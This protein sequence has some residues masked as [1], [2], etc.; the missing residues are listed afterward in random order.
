MEE[1]Y[2]LA[3]I[4]VCCVSTALNLN[5][6]RTCNIF[7]LCTLFS[8]SI[9]Y[10][11]KQFLWLLFFRIDL[12]TNKS[13][14]VSFLLMK[15]YLPLTLNHFTFPKKLCC[16]EDLILAGACHWCEAYQLAT[17]HPAACG[18]WLGGR[19]C[20]GD[21]GGSRVA[22]GPHQSWLRQWWLGQ[23]TRAGALPVEWW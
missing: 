22:A 12:W 16:E 7:C 10:T 5:Y 4:M 19:D 23:E 18:A 11:V 6:S 3:S 1:P 13:S 15:L 9:S 17:T 20:K 21:G 8:F 14:L 2:D